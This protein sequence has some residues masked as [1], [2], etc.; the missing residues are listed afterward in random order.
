[1]RIAI[2]FL[3]ISVNLFSQDQ[4]FVGKNSE[5]LINKKVILKEGKP[6]YYGFYKDDKLQELFAKDGFSNNPEKLKGIEF[7]VIQTM[8]NPNGFKM[9]R[10][11][12][13]VLESDKTGKIYYA[14]NSDIGQ[15]F[16]LYIIDGIILPE[17][18]FC[19]KLETE[20]D[21]FS[22]KITTKT[23]ENS[24]FTIH[25]IV[26]NDTIKLYL[27]LEIYKDKLS[28]NN[29]GVKI[30]L[31]DGTIL[32]RPNADI[33]ISSGTGNDTWG[34][35]CFIRLHEDDLQTY[36]SKTITDYLL[37]NYG[38]KMVESNALELREYLKCMTK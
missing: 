28:L 13:L 7:T 20:E 21:K 11:L 29:K 35:T 22:S 10:D 4:Y 8:E 16:E 25:Q 17:G 33:E 19:D 34:Y 23:P 31:S 5:L 37:G 2:L 15:S 26:E 12:V 36:S 38:R 3:M 6:G 18:Y 14:Y 32:S 1:M 27:K 24:Q 30:L 9:G